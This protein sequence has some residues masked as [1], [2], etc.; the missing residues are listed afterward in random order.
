MT[1]DIRKLEK[2][3]LNM[4]PNGVIQTQIVD[5][6]MQILW[7][8]KSGDQIPDALTN[9]INKLKES[10]DEETPVIVAPANSKSTGK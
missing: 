6:L 4:R 10:R 8:F 9:A 3:I 1:D 2:I 7:I 5:A